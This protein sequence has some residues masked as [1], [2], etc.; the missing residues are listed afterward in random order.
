LLFVKTK[1]TKKT[2]ERRNSR[3]DS[4]KD[5]IIKD[6]NQSVSFTDNI[7]SKEKPGASREQQSR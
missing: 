1:K 2:Q 6:V 3:K 7:T 4:K 5:K